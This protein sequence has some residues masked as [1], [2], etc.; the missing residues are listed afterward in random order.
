MAMRPLSIVPSVDKAPEL[1]DLCRLDSLYDFSQNPYIAALHH[2]VW[3]DQLKKIT[4]TA[5]AL[6]D[7]HLEVLAGISSRL[8][9]TMAELKDLHWQLDNLERESATSLIYRNQ[10]VCFSRCVQVAYSHAEH[11]SARGEYIDYLGTKGE[12]ARKRDLEVCLCRLRSG[13]EELRACSVVVEHLVALSSAANTEKLKHAMQTVTRQ[14]ETNIR[15][16]RGPSDIHERDSSATCPQH[17]LASGS[18]HVY[19]NP[20]SQIPGSDLCLNVESACRRT[21]GTTRNNNVQG[22][23]AEGCWT[24]L[25]MF[26]SRLGHSIIPSVSPSPIPPPPCETSTT[27]PSLTTAYDNLAN[28]LLDRELKAPMQASS[29]GRSLQDAPTQDYKPAVATTSTAPVVPTVD[30]KHEDPV[31]ANQDKNN[32]KMRSSSQSFQF[33]DSVPG[34]LKYRPSESP[35]S[36]SSELDSVDWTLYHDAALAFYKSARLSKKPNEQEESKKIDGEVL[37]ILLSTLRSWSDLIVRLAAVHAVPLPEGFVRKR[38]SKSGP[39]GDESGAGEEASRVQRSEW[40]DCDDLDAECN[41]QWD[42]GADM[43][44]GDHACNKAD[45]AEGGMTSSN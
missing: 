44:G 1:R 38:T 40:K 31:L 12:E 37:Q 17:V 8:N 33:C 18:E 32:R 43:P 10:G 39:S 7:F 25:E 4:T 22:S 3:F 41:H 16:E 30:L 6:L 27:A 2:E 29:G 45:Q 21:Q 19:A 5:P 28:T 9:F 35:H 13:W 23:Q 42:I 14:A 11:I 26:E 34:V 20:P 24:G 15:V 36:A